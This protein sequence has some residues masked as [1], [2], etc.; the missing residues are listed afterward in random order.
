VSRKDKRTG[1]RG[2]GGG[3]GGGSF[4]E[5]KRLSGSFLGAGRG[6]WEVRV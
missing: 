6:H 1:M 2:G 5:A 3:G 4:P